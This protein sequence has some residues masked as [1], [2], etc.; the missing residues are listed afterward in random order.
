V[1]QLGP[2]FGTDCRVYESTNFLVLLPGPI[3]R[4][5]RYVGFVE[6]TFR[7][8][9]DALGALA[10]AEWMGKFV[11]LVAPNQ[12]RFVEYVAEFYADGD[13]MLPG[14]IYLNRGYGHIVLPSIH[15]ASSERTLAHEMAH[16]LTVHLPMPSWVGEGVAMMAEGAVETLA[17]FRMQTSMS[18][19]DGEMTPDGIADFWAGRSFAQVGAPSSRSYRLAQRMAR[20]FLVADRKKFSRAVLQAHWRDSGFSAF[21]EQFGIDPAQMI[22]RLLGPGDWSRGHTIDEHNV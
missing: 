7:R 1:L 21:R 22:E 15:E 9:R 19:E 3:D 4:G 2:Q 11:I 8:L 12:Q 6:Q 16:A 17:P 14:G 20:E 13:Y 18:D 10:L 5:K